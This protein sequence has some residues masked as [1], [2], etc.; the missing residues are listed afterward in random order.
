MLKKI[1]LAAG[2][3]A[4]VGAPIALQASERA[5][6]PV[7]GEQELGGGNGLIAALAGAVLIAFIVLTATDDDEP[8]SP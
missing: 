4:L 7:Q 5:V 3:V 8:V 2:A 6:A 1:G